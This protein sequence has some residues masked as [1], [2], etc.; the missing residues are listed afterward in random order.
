MNL[1]VQI[2]PYKLAFEE[3]REAAKIIEQ[4]LKEKAIA[5]SHSDWAAPSVLPFEL[6]GPQKYRYIA[7]AVDSVTKFV[8]VRPLRGTK[9]KGMDSEEVADFLQT[10]V[11]HRY[12]GFIKWSLIVVENLVQSLRYFAKLGALNMSK[13][14]LKTQKLT[15][16]LSV[17][18]V[19]LNQLCGNVPTSTPANGINTLVGSLAICEQ[20]L[21]KLL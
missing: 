15:D 16:R 12:P 14:P 10:E 20:P 13:L 3:Q 5:R 17:I 11:L 9:A 4:L 21:R 7:V 18:C 6:S 1:T 19:S 2:R 8:E